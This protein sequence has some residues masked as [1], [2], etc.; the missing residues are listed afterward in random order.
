[1]TPNKTKRI[2]W[3]LVLPILA[4]VGLAA[5][6]LKEYANNRAS[7]RSEMI[8]SAVK[9]GMTEE[10]LAGIAAFQND[11]FHRLDSGDVEVRIVGLS[12]ACRCHVRMKNSVAIDATR[13]CWY[14]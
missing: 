3:Q 12:L 9:E 1:M 7:E 2:R 8:C 14:P 13:A 4:G 5:F 11:R 6:A 10:D